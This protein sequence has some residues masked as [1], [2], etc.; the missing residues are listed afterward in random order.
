MHSL[1]TP[2]GKNPESIAEQPG[3]NGALSGWRFRLQAPLLAG[4]GFHHVGVDRA[5][6]RFGRLPV[7]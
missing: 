1:Q 2:F 3:S 5:A 4:D 7:E 6:L